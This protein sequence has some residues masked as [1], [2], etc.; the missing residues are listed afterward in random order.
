MALI[1]GQPQA[2]AA[3]EAD[4]RQHGRDPADLAQRLA[5]PQAEV[6]RWAARDLADCPGSAQALVDRLA[7]EPDE[8]VR[9]VIL[10][11]LIELGDPVAVHGLVACMRSDDAALRNEAIEAMKQLPDAVS[12]IMRG[13]LLDEDS[14]MRIFAVNILESLRHP[15]VETWLLEVIEHD[16]HVNVC[17]TAVDLLGEVGSE[18]AL[19]AL[20]ALRTRFVGEPYIQFAADLAIK[21]IQEG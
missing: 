5:D 18:R 9:E 2:G 13:L 1:K 14:D 17:A 20:Q 11:S 8:S 3:R 7:E 19:D 12:P 15:S 4:T 16:D 21:R 10:T 6:R